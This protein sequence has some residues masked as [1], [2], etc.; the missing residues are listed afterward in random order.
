MKTK[1]FT[2]LKSITTGLIFLL[3]LG[4]FPVH[5]QKKVVGYVYTGSSVSQVDFTKITHLNIAFE[6]PDDAGNLSY[7]SGNTAYINAAHS[8]NVKV[9]VSI[10]GGGESTKPVVQ[11]RYFNLIKP[12]NRA[13]FISKIVA[14]LNNHGFDGIDLDLEGDAINSDYSGFVLDLKNALPAG[15]LLTA[16][17]THENGGDKVSSSAVQAFDF[18][19]IMAYDS[20]WGSAVHHST[21]SFAVTSIDWWMQNKGLLASKVILG[22]PFYGYTGIV[23]SGDIAYSQIISNHGSAAANQDTWNSSGGT[24]YYNGVPTIRQKS[25]LVVDQNYGGIMIWQLSHDLPSTNSLSLLNNVH[26][27]LG[28]ACTTPLQPGVISGNTSVAPGSSQTYSIASVSGATSYTWSLPSG[29]SGS[30]TSTSITT[31]VGAT[32]G[33]ISVRANNG[34]GAGPVRTLSV[35]VSCSV[36]SQ[37]GAISGSTTVPAGSSQTY[38]IAAVSG[39][40]SYTWSLPSGWSGSSTSTSITTTVGASGG[41]ISV[42]ANNTCGTSAATSLNVTIGTP[43]ANLA[44][45]KPVTT[46]SV[47]PN[48]TLV[49]S[50]AVDGNAG[51]RWSSSFVDP[52]WISV[53][54]N[55]SYS[56]N[57][58]KITWET[59]LGRNYEIQISNNGS[60]WTT[61]RP[62]VGNTALVNDHTGLSGTGRYIRIYGTVRGTQWGYSIF[63]L[64]VYGTTGCTMPLQPGAISGNANVTPGSTQTY[65]IAAVSN[66]T[67][68]TWSLPSGWSGTSTS[69]SITTTAGNAGG[70]ISVLA[71][72]SCGSSTARTLSVSVSTPTGNLALNKSVTTSSIEPGTTFNGANAVDGN[73]STRWSS[74]YVDPSWITVDLAGEYVIT[75]VKISWEAAYGRN[76]EVQLS[77][78]GTNWS[79]LKSV[80]NNTTLVNDHTLLSGAGRYVRIYGTTRSTQWGYS[81]FE[82]EVYGA[83]PGARGITPSVVEESESLQVY[84]TVVKGSTLNIKA[85]NF[86]GGRVKIINI[87][88]NRECINSMVETDVVDISSLS[89]GHYLI[90]MIKD[91][92]MVSRRF[93]KE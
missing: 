89:A 56:I 83:L 55:Q 7:N 48:S 6:N 28:G 51:T 2:K 38:S 73:T 60:T 69:T 54:L 68:Y 86:Q 9:L 75:R 23:G 67:S 63:E 30:S 26:Q 84:P 88:S 20:G 64:E 12:S 14:Y 65:S 78:D 15:K 39:A 87:I 93:V 46:S 66:A 53:D 58:V 76:Y 80:T 44:L 36:P 21:Y 17:L 59:A 41:I 11:A 57:R 62:V 13:A 34:C 49:G 47:E 40:T 18:L 70:T 37:P 50:N 74:N 45:N 24:I 42:R 5:A 81:I 92:R 32:G 31:T 52:S 3:M 22:V 19:N 72:N 91:N 29:W 4:L 25:Q 8:N 43:S 79:T 16:A 85:D 35:S 33:T 82:L 27:V 90:H 10:C 1:R 71:N 61:L 77:S